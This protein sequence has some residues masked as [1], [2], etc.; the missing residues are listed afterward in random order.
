MKKFKHI[1]INHVTGF[2]PGVVSKN[3][4]VKMQ[5]KFEGMGMNQTTVPESLKYTIYPTEEYYFSDAD[6]LWQDQNTH[7][8]FS[9]TKE[10]N[11]LLFIKLK[12]AIDISFLYM[13]NITKVTKVSCHKSDQGKFL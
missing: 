7:H 3:E 8:S 9:Y 6:K 5:I 11:D 4:A 2:K 13:K 1:L 10:Y 12:Y